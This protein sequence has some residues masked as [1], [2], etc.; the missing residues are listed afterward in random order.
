[1]ITANEMKLTAGSKFTLLATSYSSTTSSNSPHSSSAWTD[2]A[3]S[4][5]VGQV[6]G[7]I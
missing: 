1:M 7:Q 4:A 3:A 5:K 2:S 6:S